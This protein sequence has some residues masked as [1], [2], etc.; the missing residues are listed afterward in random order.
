MAKTL[1]T[2]FALSGPDAPMG[3]VDGGA[4]VA[5]VISGSTGGGDTTNFLAGD[6][7]LRAAPNTSAMS[8]GAAITG[9]EL[10]AVYQGGSATPVKTTAGAVVSGAAASGSIQ[11]LVAS[12]TV[13]FPG[14]PT[15]NTH[16]AGQLYTSSGTVLISTG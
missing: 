1:T 4:S 3:I 7:T 15:S 5:D 9:P 16:V 14:L 12:G 2:K 8:S 13:T 6:G 10:I 11:N